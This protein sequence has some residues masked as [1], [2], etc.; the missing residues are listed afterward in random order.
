MSNENH[1]KK[2]PTL[3]SLK[4]RT[5]KGVPLYTKPGATAGEGGAARLDVCNRGAS[6]FKRHQQ[7]R[8]A[9]KG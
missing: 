9:T 4:L 2:Y 5:P 1:Q 3:S 7:I 6:V 8:R